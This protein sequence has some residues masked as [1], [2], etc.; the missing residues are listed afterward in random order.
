MPLLWVHFSQSFHY[1]RA[2]SCFWIL[3]KTWWN[4]WLLSYVCV[5]VCAGWSLC[6]GVCVCIVIETPTTCVVLKYEK[7]VSPFED[8]NILDGCEQSTTLNCVNLT[9]QERLKRGLLRYCVLGMLLLK[10]LQC[11]ALK[12]EE[13]IAIENMNRTRWLWAELQN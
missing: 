3:T 2:T 9:I 1:Q 10:P 8:I 6:V 4:Q 7:N 12:Y 13:C 11:V 5:C